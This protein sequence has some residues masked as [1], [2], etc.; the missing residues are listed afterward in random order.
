MKITV[1]D[2]GVGLSEDQL[3][4]LF[5]AGTQ[6]NANELQGGGGSGLGLSIARGIV[7]QH[8]GT[9]VATSEGIGHGTS[10][11]VSLPVV[12]MAAALTCESF[13]SSNETSQD[14]SGLGDLPVVD[15]TR[16]LPTLSKVPECPNKAK[17][18][19]KKLR[20]LVVDDAMSNR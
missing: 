17:V 20:V 1:S 13:S 2:S 12:S 15:L 6:F 4:K 16:S 19:T 5:R 10:F 18:V 9:I 11:H 14:V 3:S 7:Q 8:Q